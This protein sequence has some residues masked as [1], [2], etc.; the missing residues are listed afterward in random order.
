MTEKEEEK[1]LI[2]IKFNFVHS[3]TSTSFHLPP[4]PPRRRPPPP[5]APPLS[6]QCL[7]LSPHHRIN[8][9]AIIIIICHYIER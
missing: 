9:T 2:H 6:P 4:R 7:G 5:P 3:L 8:Y 1:F